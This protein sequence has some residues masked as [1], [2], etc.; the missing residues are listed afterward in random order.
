MEQAPIANPSQN[1]NRYSGAGSRS[2]AARSWPDGC[3]QPNPPGAA[4]G[5]GRSASTAPSAGLGIELP[6]PRVRVEFPCPQ[7]RVAERV[8]DQCHH[9]HTPGVP[10]AAHPGARFQAG[11]NGQ[12]QQRRHDEGP[13]DRQGQVGLVDI[14]VLDV[15]QLVQDNGVEGGG[16]PDRRDR[17]S[18]ADD[19]EATPGAADANAD[20]RASSG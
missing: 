2:A 18:A 12:G 16:L 5:E 15:G 3:L 20:R 17:R 7:D 8:N 14:A 4:P 11:G 1:P 10:A 13:P 19:H 6:H 9:G